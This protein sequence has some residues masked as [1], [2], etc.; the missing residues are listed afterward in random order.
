LAFF[1]KCIYIVLNWIAGMEWNTRVSGILSFMSSTKQIV[2]DIL[3]YCILIVIVVVVT[4]CNNAYYLHN[5]HYFIII[6]MMHNEVK[7]SCPT[8]C[9]PHE[10]PLITIN[11]K[12][13]LE[14]ESHIFTLNRVPIPDDDVHSKLLCIRS[15]FS[16]FLN[17]VFPTSYSGAPIYILTSSCCTHLF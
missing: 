12:I 3:F 11:Y 13:F 8:Y 9:E 6:V 17:P 4:V 1:E 2:L 5:G 7:Y 10:P 16:D 15:N 14:I